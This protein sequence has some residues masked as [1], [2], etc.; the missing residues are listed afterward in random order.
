GNLTTTDLIGN[1]VLTL[2]RNPRELKKLQDDPALIKNAVE[3]MLRFES[4]VL[5]SGRTP[6]E[7][8]TIA[9]TQVGA[10]ES[11]TPI[12][13][14]SNRDPSVCARLLRSYTGIRS[15]IVVE[16]TAHLAETR[17]PLTP[18][19]VTSA[20]RSSRSSACPASEATA[21]TVRSAEAADKG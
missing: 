9:G 6:L 8:R 7:D 2:L 14:A 20:A 15:R 1:G 4:P 10:G 16:S 3:E 21:Q 11:V 5:M 18:P 13:A 12:L 19:S 17:T